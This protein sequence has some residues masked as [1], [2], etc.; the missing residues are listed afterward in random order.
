MSTFL[1]FVNKKLY[2]QHIINYKYNT[3]LAKLHSSIKKKKKRGK[4]RGHCE[5]NPFKRI[6]ELYEY[7]SCVSPQKSENKRVI[8]RVNFTD[9]K[10][11]IASNLLLIYLSESAPISLPIFSLKKLN[12]CHAWVWFNRY[13]VNIIQRRMTLCLV[14][15]TRAR[16]Q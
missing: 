4:R 9:W 3:E 6:L 7:L 13:K 10:S 11:G 15:K 8:T 1:L 12:A 2:C 5:Y 16:N 14:C